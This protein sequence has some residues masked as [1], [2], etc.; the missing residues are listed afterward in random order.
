MALRLIFLLIFPIISTATVPVYS[1][2]N[3]THHIPGAISVKTPC[4]P[5]LQ[6]FVFN[7]F[8]YMIK[9]IKAKRM[10]ITY[11]DVQSLFGKGHSAAWRMI[12]TAR[13]GLNKQPKQILSIKEFC[14]YYSLNY[15]ETLK[16]LDLL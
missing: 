6:H 13:D 3:T 1:G 16:H 2:N 9:E 7:P 4:I 14:N 15:D 11:K 10:H 12:Q 5:C 8:F